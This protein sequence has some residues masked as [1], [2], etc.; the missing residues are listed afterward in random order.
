MTIGTLVVFLDR[1]IFTVLLF[2]PLDS[3]FHTNLYIG[4][5]G[6]KE[7]LNTETLKRELDNDSRYPLPQ[8]E[9]GPAQDINE[10]RDVSLGNLQ[11]GAAVQPQVTPSSQSPRKCGLY[12]VL[13]LIG[14]VFFLPFTFVAVTLSIQPVW[15]S[16]INKP[17]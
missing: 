12:V 8:Q 4:L 3:I 6:E 15:P 13:G 7:G 5:R 16:R 14:I 10:Q 9:N 1:E 11:D 17:D 2:N